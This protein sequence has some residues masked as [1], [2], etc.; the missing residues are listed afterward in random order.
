MKGNTVNLYPAGI[1]IH[2]DAFWL[3]ASPDRKVY[4]Q[5]RTQDPFGLLEIKCPSMSTRRSLEELPYLEEVN[6]KLQLKR[7]DR[8]YY[9]IQ[10]QLAVTGLEWCDFFVW[11]VDA[12]HLE[13]INFDQNFW[14]GV[15]NAVDTFFFTY[16]L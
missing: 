3:A 11:S 6:G 7:S 12:C 10:M 1:I 5:S 14:N 13:T 9:Q 15:K 4:D 16:H 2:P 8:Y